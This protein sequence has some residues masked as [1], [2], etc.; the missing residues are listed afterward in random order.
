MYI[1]FFSDGILPGA[2]ALS[3]EQR[4]WEEVRDLSINFFLVSP[5]LNLPF[6][7]TVHP[8]LE[9]VFNLLLAWAAM[10][11]GFLSDERKTKPNLFN[12]GP[13]LIGMQFLTSAFLLPYL[14]LRTSEK[15]E[16]D[17]GIVYKEDISGTFQP[18]IAEWK[19]LGLFLGSVGTGSIF[20]ALMARP[21]FGGLSDRYSTFLDLLSIDRVGSSFLVDLFIFA[22]FQGWF[23]DDDLLRRGVIKEEMPILRNSAKFIPFF[24]LAA[25]LTFRPE[26]PTNEDN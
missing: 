25:Y 16:E 11:A 24:G 9:G 17:I 7:P 10:F 18:L 26:F 3:L 20:W 13:C 6:A 15:N 1:V 8:M 23:I 2:N 14:F 19:A 5:V 4:T 22:L 12:F 21:E